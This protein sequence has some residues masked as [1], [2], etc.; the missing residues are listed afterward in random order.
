M[1]AFSVS[2]PLCET[3]TV[4]FTQSSTTPEGILTTWE[5]DFGDGTPLLTISNGNPVTHIY[6]AWGSI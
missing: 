6:S 1:A 5:W 2:A 4:T 3:K